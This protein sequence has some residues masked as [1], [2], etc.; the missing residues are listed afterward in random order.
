M[1]QY[2]RNNGPQTH[3]KK[4]GTPT[5]GGIIII[6]SIVISVL[7]WGD[8]SNKFLLIM[9]AAII[10]FGCIGLTDDYLKVVKKNPRGLCGWYKFDRVGLYFLL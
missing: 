5:M 2:V 9:M 8:L 1:T 7:M 4:E 3:L 10:G 6:L